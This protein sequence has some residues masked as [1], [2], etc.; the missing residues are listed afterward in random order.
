MTSKSNHKHEYKDCVFEYNEN[1]FSRVHGYIPQKRSVIGSYCPIC[2]KIGERL[3]LPDRWSYPRKVQGKDYWETIF[4]EEYIREINPD[5]RTI[6]TFF[7]IDGLYQK[8]IYLEVFN[9]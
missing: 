4:T 1:K 3:G 2:G 7:L 6:P 9:A 8:H 5:T